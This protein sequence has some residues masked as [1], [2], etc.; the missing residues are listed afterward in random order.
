MIDFAAS[1][2]TK[3]GSENLSRVEREYRDMRTSCLDFRAARS[4]LCWAS[5]ILG[6]GFCGKSYDT[7]R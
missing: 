7:S 1:Y 5:D 6:N 3:A 4:S 2:L